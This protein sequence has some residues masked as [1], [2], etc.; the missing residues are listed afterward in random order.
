MSRKFVILVLLLFCF[1]IF[2]KIKL[3]KPSLATTS[4]YKPKR[5]AIYYGY[6]SLVN[7]ANWD[8]NKAASEFAFFDVIVF[9]DGIEHSG[10]GDHANTKIIIQKLRSQ[11]KEVFGYVDMGIS[12]VPAQN[13][14]IATAQQYVDEWAKMG[15]SGIFWDDA[16]FDFHV[17][18]E[19]QNTL[20]NYSH[21]KGLTVT[22][23]ASSPRSWKAPLANA[24]DRGIPPKARICCAWP[25]HVWND[26][27]S[28]S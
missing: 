8:V 4:V 16:G 11:G 14:S 21:S 26:R 15:V 5:L 19:R 17:T 3:V 28:Q 12:P 10:H 23:P 22:V 9:G 20:V 24:G 27:S 2:S 1:V 6:P 18:R 13:L 7:G 25:I